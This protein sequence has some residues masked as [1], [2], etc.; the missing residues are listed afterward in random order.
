[1]AAEKALVPLEQKQVMFHENE[2]TAALV[3]AGVNTGAQWQI[4][5]HLGLAFAGQRARLNRAPVFSEV[6]RIV[7]ITIA[8][9]QRGRLKA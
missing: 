6:A 1:M 2:I 4:G 9:P 3:R 8:I 7:I 5:N